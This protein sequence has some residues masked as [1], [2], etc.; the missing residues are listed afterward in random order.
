MKYVISQGISGELTYYTG[1]GH[2]GNWSDK[3]SEAQQFDTNA[4]ATDEWN[5]IK[6]RVNNCHWG[7]NPANPLSV[8]LELIP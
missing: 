2:F 3:L 1:K 5:K 7:Y 8:S 4:Q 6:N